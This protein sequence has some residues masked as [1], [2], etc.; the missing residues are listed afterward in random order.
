MKT[1]IDDFVRAYAAS[2]TVRY[3]MPG[4]KGCGA[5][6][7]AYDITE[8]EGADVLD[9]AR[10]IIAGSEANASSLFGTEKTVYSCGGSSQC[11]RAMVY[12]AVTSGR[13]RKVLAARNA[14]RS[15]V[16][17]CALCDAEIVWMMP[18]AGEG[19]CSCRVS[20]ERLEAALGKDDFCAVYLTSPDYLGATQDIGALSA[21]CRRHR[22]PL[23]CDNA[24][25]AYLRFLPRDLHPASRGAALCC[26]SAHKT[27]P[28]LT[29]GAYLHCAAGDAFGFAGRM[30]GAMALFGTTSPSWLILASLDRCNACLAGDYPARLARTVRRI[31]A[32]KNALFEA[33][34]RLLPSDPLRITLCAA[35]GEDGCALASRLR[36]EGAEC[37]YASPEHLVL[38]LSPHNRAEE[39]AALPALLGPAKGEPEA[40]IPFAMPEP[41]RAMT[42][43]EAVFSAW[44]EAAAEDAVGRVCALPRTPCPPGVPVVCAGEI[45][46]RE[47][48]KIM[49][50]YGIETVRVAVRPQKEEKIWSIPT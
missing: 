18:E 10:G 46:S 1:P 41:E 47:A 33:G 31:E 4:H 5:H 17:A 2:G 32:V 19:L 43:R 38:M 34:W 20:P 7:E 39:I 24:H 9:E 21:V 44:E 12:L 8:I 40:R 13:G 45:I 3:H 37:E 28:V 48:V 25:G 49:R 15:F 23:L 42:P 16:D 35:S 30:K 26:D 11:V 29:G 27:L 6:G 14:H 22:V 36:R 50:A